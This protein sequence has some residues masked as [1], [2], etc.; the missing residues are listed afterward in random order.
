MAVL[1]WI[2]DLKGYKRW[3]GFFVVFGMNPLFIYALA[4]VWARVLTRLIKIEDGEKVV[5]GYNW[6]YINVSAVCR[7]YQRLVAIRAVAHR[8]ILVYLLPPLQVAHIH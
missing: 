7:R 1:I 8:G 6:L 2:I 4:G 5:N 3:T